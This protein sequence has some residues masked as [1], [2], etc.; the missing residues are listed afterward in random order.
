MAVSTAVPNDEKYD[1][2]N[3]S[4]VVVGDVT[5]VRGEMHLSAGF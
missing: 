2:G 4:E 1:E 5:D 3:G